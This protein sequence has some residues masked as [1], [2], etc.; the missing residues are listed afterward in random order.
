MQRHAAGL[1]GSPTPEQ[2]E[3]K[4]SYGGH[5]I[6]AFAHQ[7]ADRGGAVVEDIDLMLIDDLQKRS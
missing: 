1:I 4:P 5:I 6:V 3:P 7:R 2:A